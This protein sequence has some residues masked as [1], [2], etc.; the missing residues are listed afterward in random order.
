MAEIPKSSERYGFFKSIRL[1]I[2]DLDGTL[3]D[4]FADI[5]TAANHALNTLGRQPLALDAITRH[6]GHGGRNLMQSCLG[7]GAT[8]EEIDK[9]FAAWRSYYANHP[10]DFAKP[11]PGVPS[12]LAKLRASGLKT[13][14]LSNKLDSLT[15]KILEALGLDKQF[16]CIQGEMPGYPRKPDPQ[17]VFAVMEKMAAL[18]EQTLLV[19]DGD[20]DMLV[21]QNAGLRAVGVTYGVCTREK[22]IQMGATATIDAFPALID[23]LGVQ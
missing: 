5:A 3:V 23:L 11:Y 17:S 19:G 22:L 14:V 9:A 21:A 6:V 16:G 2:F 13:A 4:A 20:A 7:A 15:R 1:L 10:A 18:P 12:T 8:E